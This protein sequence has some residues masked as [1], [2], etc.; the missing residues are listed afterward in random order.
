MSLVRRRKAAVAILILD[1]LGDDKGSERGKTREWIKKQKQR[2]MFITMKK[3]KM[4]DTRGFKE[5]MRMGPEQFDQILQAIEPHIFK[6]CT[7]MDG[8]IGCLTGF[9][10][11]SSSSAILSTNI[12]VPRTPRIFFSFPS[13][14]A[15]TS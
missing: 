15:K 1:L 10:T 8:L 6:K 4:H 14:R 7:K 13:S 11:T 5:M 3:L 2:G 9:S 12:K